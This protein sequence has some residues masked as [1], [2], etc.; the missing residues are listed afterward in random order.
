MKF[1]PLEME[2]LRG[3]PLHG[4]HFAAL[5]G[6]PLVVTLGL[7]VYNRRYFRLPHERGS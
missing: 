6:I 5:L 2:A 4:V 7:I 3:M 1:A